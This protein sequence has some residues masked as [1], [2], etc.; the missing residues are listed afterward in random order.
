VRAHLGRCSTFWLWALVGA[1]L[2]FSVISALG[3]LTGLPALAALFL[4]A[5]RSTRWPEPLGLLAGFG[6]LCLVVAGLNWGGEGLDA[7]PWLTAG[8]AL[9][10]AGVAAYWAA[11]RSSSP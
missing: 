5:R 9:V 7:G 3:L 4:V 11:A 8:L 6:A 2:L 10:V 1:A